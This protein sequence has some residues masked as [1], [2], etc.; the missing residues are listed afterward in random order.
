MPFQVSNHFEGKQMED[1]NVYHDDGVNG[2]GD[3]Q[4]SYVSTWST[5]R[6]CY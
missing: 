1:I 5:A 4:M 6:N 3:E 2:A